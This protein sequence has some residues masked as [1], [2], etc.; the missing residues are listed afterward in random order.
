MENNVRV[1]WYKDLEDLVKEVYDLD[2]SILGF[3]VPDELI[4]QNTY[5]QFTV[6]GESE[7]DFIGDD[8]IVAEW[9]RTGQTLGLAMSEYDS[10]SDRPYSYSQRVEVRHVLHRLYKDDIIPSGKYLMTVYW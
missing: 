10:F 8:D 7:L 2:I 4:H 9:I 3:M 1:F 5:H 6:D